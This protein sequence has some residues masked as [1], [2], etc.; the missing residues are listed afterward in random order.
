ML[1]AKLEVYP[2]T[3]EGTRS[4][5]HVRTQIQLLELVLK[6]VTDVYEYDIHDDLK[7]IYM[8]TCMP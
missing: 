7:K 6:N 3:G 5:G 2:S 1:I 4:H 8:S